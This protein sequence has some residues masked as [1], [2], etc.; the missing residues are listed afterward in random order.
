MGLQA[1]PHLQAES[2]LGCEV[3]DL[4]KIERL[5]ESFAFKPFLGERPGH[6]YWAEENTKMRIGKIKIFKKI[7]PTLGPKRFLFFLNQGLVLPEFPLELCSYCF[8]HCSAL[9]RFL[10]DTDLCTVFSRRPAL[11]PTLSPASSSVLRD[12]FLT[13]NPPCFPS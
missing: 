12:L 10:S 9:A 3:S 1:F 6:W 8:F 2:L 11:A 4:L 7:S 13:M 5:Q